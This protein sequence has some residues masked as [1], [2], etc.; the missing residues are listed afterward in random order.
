[1]YG[2]EAADMYAQR[3]AAASKTV[4]VHMKI[5]TGLGRMG[6]F[7]EDSAALAEHAR[8]LGGINIEG[9]FTHLSHV[10]DVENDPF[11]PIPD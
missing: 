9:I 5:D 2:K 11:T 7:A 8:S 3:A 10:E 6:V 1:M 4:N